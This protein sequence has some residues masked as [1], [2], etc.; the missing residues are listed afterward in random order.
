VDHILYFSIVDT[1]FLRQARNVVDP[2]LLPGEIPQQLLKVVYNYYDETPDRLAPANFIG[3][4]FESAVRRGMVKKDLEDRCRKKLEHLSQMTGENKGFVLR[5]LREVAQSRKF[6]NACRQLL[7]DTLRAD[8][9]DK[10]TGQRFFSKEARKE[11]LRK[12]VEEEH[13][14]M[15]FMIEP[16]DSRGAYLARKMFVLI[17]GPEKKG[18]TWGGTHIGKVGLL[19]GKNVLHITHESGVTEDILAMR[20]EMNLASVGGQHKKDDWDHVTPVLR[21]GRGGTHH[22]TTR[23]M[24]PGT[25]RDGKVDRIISYMQNLGGDLIIKEFSRGSCSMRAL[26]NYIDSLEITEGFIP[27][28]IINDYPDIMKLPGGE[29]R[30]GI[31]K[32]YQDHASLASERDCL[33]VAFSQVKASA[34]HKKNI[35]MSDFAED[36]RKAAHCDLAFAL[37]QTTEEEERGRVR[38]VWVVD[39]HF[40]CERT[41]AGL[42]QDYSIGQFCKRAYYVDEIDAGEEE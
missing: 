27:D 42:L 34:Y 10:S 14:L 36:K 32:I 39:R 12:Y 1:P 20:Y 8:I 2:D 26:E 17:M 35:T 16:F 11:R 41:V 33:V 4:E 6:V 24:K 23:K 22:L 30:H 25:V 13:V 3:D 28:I 9:S 21:E 29:Y 15:P 19:H 40:Q 37:C 38:F 5:K 7:V 18:K 31:D